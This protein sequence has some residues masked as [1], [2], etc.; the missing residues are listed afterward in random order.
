MFLIDDALQKLTKNYDRQKLQVLCYTD[1][2][3]IFSGIALNVQAQV[4]TQ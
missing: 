1:I 4:K 2:W 3:W